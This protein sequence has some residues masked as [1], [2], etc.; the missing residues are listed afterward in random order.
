MPADVTA[1]SLTV[2]GQA[3]SWIEQPETVDG[4][5]DALTSVS[6]P[7]LVAGGGT[8]LSFGNIGGPFEAAISTMK[9]NGIIH[10]EPADLTVAVEPGVTVSQIQR[11]L[12]EQ[13]QM[14][15][16]DCA[17][18]DRVTLGGLFASGLGGPRRLRY[19]SMR[20]WVLGVEVM[21]ASGLVT[22]SGGMVVKNVTGYDLTQLHYA[23]HGAFGIVTRLNLKVVPREE[24]S[25]SVL[26]VYGSAGEAHRAGLSVLSSQIEPASILVSRDDGWQLSVRCDGSQSS[27]EWQANAVV[28]AATSGAIPEKVDVFE[29]GDAAVA[30]FISAS[31]LT[32]TS[33]VARI[34]SPPSQQVEVLER[35]AG[36]VGSTMCADLGSG[37]VYISG[38]ASLEWREAVSQTP[39]A[40]S[41]T[42]FLSL[43]PKIKAGIDVFGDMATSNAGLVRTLKDAFDPDGRFNRG[44]FVLGL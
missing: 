20:D 21:D 17:H 12:G 18:P 34:S 24:A 28:D 27:I 44:R 25:R 26:M 36:L 42:S 40:T 39:G 9:L 11:V 16:I 37:L 43:P 4:L 6:G 14:L 10:Y 30:P 15:P 31:D 5:R 41:S 7:V 1:G 8:H 23:A 29:D 33:A 22:K 38:P 2:D 19:G 13:N 35:Y 3:V 32:G